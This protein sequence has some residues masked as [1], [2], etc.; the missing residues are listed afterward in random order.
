MTDISITIVAYHNYGDI[1]A[2]VESI[3]KFTDSA[4]DKKIYIVDN[5]CI[6][7][8]D[9]VKREF[10]SFLSQW[11]DVEYL[12]TGDNLGFG[13]GHNYVL[14]RLDSKYHGIVNPDIL[15]TEDSLGKMLA[16]MEQEQEV[17]ILVPKLVDESGE[18]IKAYRRELTVLDMFIRFCCPGMFRKRKAYHTMDEMDY[19]KAF[20]VP[21]AQG[22]FLI[23]RTDL[24]RKLEGFDDRFFMYLED[25]DL[26]KRANE[27]SAVWYYP[28]TTVI[29]KWEKG[30]HKSSRLLKIHL[31]SMYRYFKKWG[32]K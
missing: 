4:I 25:A 20:H 15:L 18:M 29:H 16:Y 32:W 14:D 31:Q 10:L 1:K 11:K 2:A 5:S 19:T 13:K 12:D 17:G 7:D 24:Y 9:S 28:D 23:V 27:I 30:S 22:S 6:K 26:C 3:E 8:E 21:F